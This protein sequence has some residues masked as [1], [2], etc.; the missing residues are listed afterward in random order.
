MEVDQKWISSTE[1]G[2]EVLEV[3]QKE[4]R[5]TGSKLEAD[6][7][8]WNWTRIGLKVLEVDQKWINRKWIRITGT[9]SSNSNPLLDHF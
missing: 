4:I 8:Y 7:K 2:L 5:S 6:Y 9:R 3:D 1:S